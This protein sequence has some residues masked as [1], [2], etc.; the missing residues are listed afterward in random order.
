MARGRDPYWLTGTKWD[1]FCSK[2]NGSIR[3][4]SRAFY[5]PNARTMLCDADACGG[6]A[7]RDFN[8][9]VADERSN[10]G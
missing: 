7:S 9:A 3:K 8:A 10:V 5:Y 4:G 6:Q 1:G 2:C